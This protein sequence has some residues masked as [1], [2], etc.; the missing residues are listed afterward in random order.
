MPTVASAL[1]HAA[2]AARARGAT[3]VAA[4]LTEQ[5]RQLTPPAR[6]AELWRR[7]MKAVEYSYEAG[8]SNRAHATR[9]G[10]GRA[11]PRQPRPGEC[12]QHPGES[13]SLAKTSRWQSACGRRRLPRSTSIPQPGPRASTA[14]QSPAWMRCTDLPA[15]A[16]HARAAVES[17]AGRRLGRA[18]EG[19]D[20]AGED[21]RYARRAGRVGDDGARRRSW[22]ETDEHSHV[23]R[24]AS[25]PMGFF[26]R[27]ADRLEE[28]RASMDQLYERAVSEGDESSIPVLLNS[29]AAPKFHSATWPR[30]SGFWRRPSRPRRGRASRISGISRSTRRSAGCSASLIG[31]ATRASGRLRSR[32]QSAGTGRGSKRSACSGFS[33]SRSAIRPRRMNTSPEPWRAPKQQGSASRA[34][35]AL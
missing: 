8:D 16:A 3:D 9:A 23:L 4:L 13:E 24:Q 32:R 20:G 7:T 28:F 15:A 22:M 25:H 18:R 29:G 21:R 1:D 30:R 19:A 6:S 11:R 35:A 27:W 26:L 33:S 34:N 5:A 17:A 31:R 2:A 14:S 10:S 12:A